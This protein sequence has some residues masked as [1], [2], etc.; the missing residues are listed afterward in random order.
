MGAPG[1]WKGT[2]KEV[3]PTP[4]HVFCPVAAAAG[5]GVGGGVVLAP[6]AGVNVILHGP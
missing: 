2:G 4:F 1:H 3:T 6:R 5:G